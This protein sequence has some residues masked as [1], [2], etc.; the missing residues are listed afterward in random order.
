MP[1]PQPDSDP[2]GFWPSCDDE[3]PG[4][5]IRPLSHADLAAWLAHLDH[6]QEPGDTL[7]SGVPAPVVAR[8][9][10][11]GVGRPGAS[12]TA[13]YR[14]QRATELATWTRSLPWR[15]AAVLAAGLVAW[16]LAV[17]VTARL[18]AV[19]AILAAAGVAWALRFHTSADTRA[20]RRGAA[21]ERRTARLLAPLER[22]GWAV[23]HD[24]TIPGSQATS[25]TW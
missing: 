1:R 7:G 11:A 16:L 22:H 24:L 12:A 15:V 17:Q 23:L 9:V 18:A 3:P 14:R 10:R 25:T 4:V 13:E 19:A 2:G 20:W 5:S 6:D 21:G 8:R